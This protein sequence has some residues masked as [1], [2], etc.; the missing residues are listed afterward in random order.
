MA[1]TNIPL[2]INVSIGSPRDSLALGRVQSM[3][4]QY[5]SLRSV[6]FGNRKGKSVSTQ[7]VTN[8]VAGVKSSSAILDEIS[9]LTKAMSSLGRSMSISQVVIDEFNGWVRPK[10]ADPLGREIV[11]DDPK[12]PGSRVEI[13]RKEM[14]K[15]HPRNP[16][17]RAGAIVRYELK[18]EMLGIA[19]EFSSL[20]AARERATELHRRTVEK[21]KHQ[22]RAINPNFGRF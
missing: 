8:A 16:N 10:S 1:L 17:P 22:M 9:Q 13:W 14:D 12:W 20:E 19:E 15:R 7:M 11:I 5:A 4:D 6:S 2:D 18:G 21:A 3:M